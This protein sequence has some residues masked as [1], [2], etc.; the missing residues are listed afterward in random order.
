MIV[1][2]ETLLITR[3]EAL[4]TYLLKQK[5][6]PALI[7]D[8]IRKVKALNR[9]DLLKTKETKHDNSLIP[10]VTTFNPHNPEV[11]PEIKN[12]KSLLLR[13]ERMKAIFSRKCF[14]K[15]KR[16]PPNL[17]KILTKAKFSKNSKEH[18]EVTKCNEPRCGLCKHLK[19][20]STYKFKDQIFNLTSNM[21]CMVKNVIYVIE[22]QGCRKY[23]IGETSNL[24]NR[25]TLHNQH[26][27]HENL[28]MIPVSGHIASCSNF[29]PKYFI[30]PFYKMKNSSIL[31]R[32]EKEKQ[33]IKKFKPELN[34]L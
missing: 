31:D 33:L 10:Y 3:L 21:T 2:D 14:L 20:G 5:Y 8:S 12:N 29:D 13:D 9:K 22:C 28:R 15:S 30:F 25:V 34:S 27:R 32:K 23:Y 6:P 26:I 19:V 17:K 18:F 11:F 24:R 1:S 4:K 7:E 16:Q